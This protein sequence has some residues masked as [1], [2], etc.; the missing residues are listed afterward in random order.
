MKI[1]QG[2][3]RKTS[4][5]ENNPDYRQTI[6]VTGH[7]TRGRKTAYDKSLQFHLEALDIDFNF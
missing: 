3:D 2:T 7:P 1:K 4:N 6:I 5:T